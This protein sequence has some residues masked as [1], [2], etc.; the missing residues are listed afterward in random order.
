MHSC[1]N[2][3][4]HC[5]AML[6]L[7]LPAPL[8][9]QEEVGEFGPDD[10]IRTL[11]VRGSTDIELFAPVMRA[12]LDRSIDT[13]IRYEQW[14]SNALYL[15]SSKECQQSSSSADVLISSAVD[16]QV[17]LVNDGCAIA[18]RSVYTRRL[19]AH[20]IWRDELFGITLEP[21]VMVYNRDELREEEIPLSRFDLLDRLRPHDS[22]FA[23]RVATYDIELSGLGYL[24]AFAD[25]QQA[26]TFGALLEAFGRTGAV[27]TCCS[28]E[29]IDAVAEGRFLVAYNVL[30]SYA[31][32]QAEL[33]PRIGIVSPQDYTLTLSRGALIPQGAP[34]EDTARAFLDFLLS[35]QGRT[36]LQK[37]HLIATFDDND[38]ADFPS[39]EGAVPVLRPISLS[40]TLLVGLDQ[41]KREIFIRQWREKMVLQSGRR[42]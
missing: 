9:A 23:G 8:P 38:M 7:C 34:Q 1:R 18:H 27:A 19:P 3:L 22:R 36:I 4:C 25:S 37:S 28:A 12:F 13:R 17:K 26:T 16:Q 33:D 11:V 24:F 35:D 21:A 20:A 14:G 30:G 42:E 29:L 41:M 15:R 31:L 32:A 39:L 5:L 6:T 2:L 40:P 10:A